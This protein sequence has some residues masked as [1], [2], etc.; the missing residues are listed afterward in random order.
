MNFTRFNLIVLTLSLVYGTTTTGC[1]SLFSAGLPSA[2]MFHQSLNLMQSQSARAANV[3]RSRESRLQASCELVRSAIELERQGQTEEAIQAY[4]AAIELWPAETDNYLDLSRLYQKM[5]QWQLANEQLSKGLKYDVDSIELNL[6]IAEVYLNQGQ[7]LRALE[8]TDVVMVQQN[9]N[10][11]C[12][13]IR[14]DAY[15]QL[16]QLE[17]SMA[18]SYRALA[19]R[20]EDEAVLERVCQIYFRQGRPM[21]SWSIVQKMSARY[22][23]ENRPSKLR[24]L[25]AQTL[26]QMNRNSDAIQTLKRWYQG[27]GESDP[28]CCVMLAQC[29]DRE[30]RESQR[31]QSGSSLFNLGAAGNDLLNTEGERTARIPDFSG[32]DIFQQ[33]DGASDFQLNELWDTERPKFRPMDTRNQQWR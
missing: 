33:L 25:E 2:G 29:L 12:W 7:P 18:A 1:Q 10:P 32:P 16:E 3:L 31:S 15:F 21:R 24:L 17:N 8:Y 20:P 22:N 13:R 30:N 5:G 14:A 11:D 19:I 26:V 23:E 9:D 27:G 6:G 28:N 4:Q